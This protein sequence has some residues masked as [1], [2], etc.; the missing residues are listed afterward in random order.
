MDNYRYTLEKY[1]GMKSSYNCPNCHEKKVFTKYIDTE[2]NEYLSDEVGSCERINNCGYHYKPKQFFDDNNFSFDKKV[3][4]RPIPKPKPE[5]SFINLEVMQKSKASKQ[6]NFFIDFLANLWDYEI[7]YYLAD[8]YNIGTSKFWNGA[9]VFFQVDESNK[10]RT[11]KIMLYNPSNGKRIKEP[12]N[13]INWVHKALKLESFNLE[14]C[15]FG[16]HLLNEDK[17]KAVAI[18]ESEKTAVIASVFLPEFIWLACGSATNL[19]EAKTQLLK[20]RNV[21][22]FPDLKCFDLWNDKIPKLTKL[23]TFRTSSLLEDKATESEKQKGLDLSDFLI[24]I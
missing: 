14:Q 9:T 7:A 8:R 1:S 17:N 3:F 19:N 13:Y 11:G 2:T 18:V 4:Q 15:L 16:E 5:T 20:G 22:L 21:V 6:P 23:A 24:N 12:C 10:I